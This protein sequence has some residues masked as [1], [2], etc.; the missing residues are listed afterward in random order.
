MEIIVLLAEAT[1][2]TTDFL[3][4]EDKSTQKLQHLISDNTQI[5][6]ACVNFKRHSNT[7]FNLYTFFCNE[8]SCSQSFIQ[9]LC[10]SLFVLFVYFDSN[11][12]FDILSNFNATIKTLAN[13]TK[14]I[15]SDNQ[16]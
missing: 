7:V 13:M 8:I 15:T 1:N 5:G 10:N 4:C 3:L 11:T 16:V 2:C 9:E 14:S 6:K 12:I